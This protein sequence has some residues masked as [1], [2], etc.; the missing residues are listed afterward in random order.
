MLALHVSRPIQHSPA[1]VV[2]DTVHLSEKP[3][4]RVH[5]KPRRVLLESRMKCL[6]RSTFHLVA[7]RTIPGLKCIT[8]ASRSSSIIGNSQP[9]PPSQKKI[10]AQDQSSYLDGA[11][12]GTSL[13][14]PSGYR[15]L[16]FVPSAIP[17]PDSP[18]SLFSLPFTRHLDLESYKLSDDCSSRT[19]SFSGPLSSALFRDTFLS[20]PAVLAIAAQPLVETVN[21]NLYKSS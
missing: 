16:H 11:T 2:I 3:E 19:P 8:C 14:R 18:S 4:I 15:T 12:V 1:D 20:S 7:A 10:R 21:L 5:L 9:F 17:A 6:F 13:I